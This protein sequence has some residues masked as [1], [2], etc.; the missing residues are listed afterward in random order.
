MVFLPDNGDIVRVTR[1][2]RVALEALGRGLDVAVMLLTVECGTGAHPSRAS[3]TVVDMIH[4]FRNRGGLF[5][6][7]TRLV[8]GADQVAIIGKGPSM[9]W[10]SQE[11]A[12]L[13]L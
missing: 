9:E 6:Q 1:G 2:L 8:F 7:C 3:Y 12:T 13:Y 4:E 5:W 10:L 11:T